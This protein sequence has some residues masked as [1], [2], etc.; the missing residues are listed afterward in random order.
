MIGERSHYLR[1]ALVVTAV[2][3]ALAA[4]IAV[5]NDGGGTFTFADGTPV[6]VDRGPLWLARLA[7][8][9]PPWIGTGIKG[10]LVVLLAGVAV[11]YHR[12]GVDEQILR[13]WTETAIVLVSVLFVA[14]GLAG[15]TWIP[16]WAGAISGG[17]GGW[18]IG[19]AVVR[20]FYWFFDG[21]DDKE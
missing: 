3:T 18:I 6:R 4:L 14:N 17:V 13:E 20:C 15:A 21:T 16:Y 11:G 8:Q 7:Y 2:A 9:P 1:T 19:Q 10:L 5:A 12:H